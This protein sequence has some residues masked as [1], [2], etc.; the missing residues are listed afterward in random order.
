VL[1]S[2]RHLAL[3]GLM[4]AGKSTVGARLAAVLGRSFVDL[5]EAVVADAGR[6]V[7]AIFAAEG[8]DGFRE[9]E[10]DALRRVL[11]GT[12]GVVLAT[13]GGVVT[14]ERNRALLARRSVVVWLD[15][16]VAELAARVGDG[17]G[18]PLLAGDPV[19]RLAALDA[20][21]RPAYEA[22]ADLAVTTTGLTPDEVV[23]AVLADLPVGAPAGERP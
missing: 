6:P 3:V 14:R 1:A 13:G 7:E 5:D 18:R 16:D 22:C 11:A 23:A 19:A 8:E 12:V 9:R 21:R 2:D 15:A 4:G 20:D 10:T 17:D